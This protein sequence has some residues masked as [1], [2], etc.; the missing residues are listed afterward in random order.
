MPH[1]VYFHVKPGFHIIATIAAIARYDVP[2]VPQDRCELFP[3]I[4]AILPIVA[5][6]WKPGFISS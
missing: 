5:I 4:A 2:Y 1:G 3:A 6:I